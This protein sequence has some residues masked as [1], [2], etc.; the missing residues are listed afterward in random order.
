M[1]TFVH[2]DYYHDVMEV[3]YCLHCQKRFAVGEEL[4]QN[5]SSIICPYCGS[6]KNNAVAWNDDDLGCGGISFHKTDGRYYDRCL[7]CKCELAA[8]NIAFESMCKT[9]NSG[10]EVSCESQ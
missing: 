3:R 10:R 2:T 4:A 7:F 8:E 5:A 9:C 6:K 1:S